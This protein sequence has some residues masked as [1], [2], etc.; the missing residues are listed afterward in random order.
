MMP[1]GGL[2]DLTVRQIAAIADGLIVLARDVPDWNVLSLAGGNVGAELGG[3][4]IG[5]L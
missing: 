3:W 2:F 4:G 1:G 5:G